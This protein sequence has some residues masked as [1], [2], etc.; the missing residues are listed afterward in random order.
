M[1]HRVAKAH[2][3]PVRQR[4][5]A[6]HAAG[7]PPMQLV[8]IGRASTTVFGLSI[9]QLLPSYVSP[10]LMTPRCWPQKFAMSD[11]TP[12]TVPAALSTIGRLNWGTVLFGLGKIW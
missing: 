11:G 4:S 3:A 10:S 7:S 5:I 1:L 2:G 12:A 9:V 6:P 8:A